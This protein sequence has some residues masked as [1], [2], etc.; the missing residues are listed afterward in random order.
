M[1]ERMP[2]VAGLFACFLCVA[3]TLVVM[4]AAIRPYIAQLQG[5]LKDM[6]AVHA[7]AAE[8]VLGEAIGRAPVESGALQASVRTSVTQTKARIRAGAVGRSKNYAARQH[9]VQQDGKPLQG[10]AIIVK[11][12]SL[13][14]SS[15]AKGFF[16][17]NEILMTI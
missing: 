10:A 5:D 16:K 3:I 8:L 1:G 12:T 4:G 7:E 15:N 11:G 2:L 17:I 13:G 9:W 6:K 14:I